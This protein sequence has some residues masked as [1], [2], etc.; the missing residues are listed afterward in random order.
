[1][2]L[3]IKFCNLIGADGKLGPPNTHTHIQAGRENLH[4][5]K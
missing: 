5:M 4:K 2:Y 3:L 1:M